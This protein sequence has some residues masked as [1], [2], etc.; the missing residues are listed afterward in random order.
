MKV[1]RVGVS[2]LDDK[3]HEFM[4]LS[5]FK[6]DLRLREDNLIRRMKFSLSNFQVDNQLFRRFNSYTIPFF[7]FTFLIKSSP[8]LPSSPFPSPPQDTIQWPSAQE[9]TLTN[10]RH[11]WKL[12]SNKHWTIE[13]F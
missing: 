11:I 6:L 9:K 8:P 10:Q 2:V 4:Y 7:V 12:I 1:G 3:M 13:Q 5:L